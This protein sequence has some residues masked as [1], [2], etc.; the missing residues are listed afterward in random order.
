MTRARLALEDGTVYTGHSVGAA[1]TVTGEAVFNTGMTGYQEVLTDPSYSGQIVAMTYPEVGNYGINPAD[2]ESQRAQ[3]AGFVMRQCCDLPSNFR[4][5]ES[6]P[7]FLRRSNI[8]GIDDIDTR[9][10]TKQLRVDGAMRAALSTDESLS[11][12]DL[13][14]RA[15][16]APD[17]AGLDLASRAGTNKIY[18][19]TEVVSPADFGSEVTW[20]TVSQPRH[21]VAI[22][23]GVKHNILRLLASCGFKVTVVPADTDAETIRQLQPDGIFVSNGP[24]DP[25]AVEHAPATLRQLIDDGYPTFGICLGHQIIALACGAKT[26]KLKFGHR[27]VNHPIQR[28]ADG[29]VEIASHNHGFAVALDSLPED[30]EVTHMNLNDQTCAGIRHRRLPVFSVQYHPEA[31]PGPSDPLYLFQRFV[32]LIDQQPI[33]A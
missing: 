3:V 26:F 4:S 17:M 2:M 25:A 33:K 5:H 1:G 29:A 32:E 11:D 23:L 7:E 15:R 22:D 28:L 12:A 27:G 6:L 8:I 10:L 14:E 18:E 24:G 19:W 20:P 9:K 31:C 16:Q 30:L 21:V 13:V